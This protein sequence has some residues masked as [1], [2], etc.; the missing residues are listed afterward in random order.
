MHSSPS[1]CLDQ[2]S[3]GTV[4]VERLFRSRSVRTEYFGSG[5][6]VG[7]QEAIRAVH[8]EGISSFGDKLPFH[9]LTLDSVLRRQESSQPGVIKLY[10]SSVFVEPDWYGA[11]SRVT[12]TIPSVRCGRP[13]PRF[14][15]TS[16]VERL[17]LSVR[18]HLRHYAAER[19][20]TV[21]SW[22]ITRRVLLSGLR[23]ITSSE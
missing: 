21:A 20:R 16:H 22:Q 15:S 9:S 18:M 14:V 17:N 12:G 13:E 23:G 1:P 7:K 4:S 11:T 6:I 10:S 8:P 5:R 3:H 19:T 2:A